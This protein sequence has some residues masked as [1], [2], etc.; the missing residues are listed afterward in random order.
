MRILLLILSEDHLGIP[1][2]S[3]LTPDNVHHLLR[4]KMEKVDAHGGYV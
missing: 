4:K 1:V 2:V 3:D